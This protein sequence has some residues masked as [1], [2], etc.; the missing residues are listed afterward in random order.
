M[1]LHDLAISTKGLSER[2]KAVMMMIYAA[3]KLKSVIGAEH[4]DTMHARR[5]VERWA[6]KL[7]VG[8]DAARAAL[9]MSL[10][11]IVQDESSSMTIDKLLD[12]MD[13]QSTRHLPASPAS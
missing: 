4:H 8:S 7:P 2:E 9:T 6:R 12:Y 10:S 13:M 11:E 1:R 5:T 3:D